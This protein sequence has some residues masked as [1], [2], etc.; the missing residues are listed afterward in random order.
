MSTTTNNKKNPK[1]KG[2]VEI[3]N[4]IRDYG[5]HSY[6]VKKAAEAKV[7]LKKAGLPK[8]IKSK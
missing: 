1:S 5:N 3:D 8:H 4:S 2:T 7:F 6:F